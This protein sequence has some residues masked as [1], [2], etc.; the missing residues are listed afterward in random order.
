MFSAASVLFFCLCVR[1]RVRENQKEQKTDWVG[2]D[3][4]IARPPA[5]HCGAIRRV[6]RTAHVVTECVMQRLAAQQQQGGIPETHRPGGDT[7]ASRAARNRSLVTLRSLAWRSG[8]AARS[9]CK[10]QGHQEA[11]SHLA[12]LAD[13]RPL[14][15]GDELAVR[16]RRE[17]GAQVLLLQQLDRGGKR[18]HLE[19][20][21]GVCGGSRREVCVCVLCPHTRAR[22]FCA[23]MQS[24]KHSGTQPR[25]RLKAGGRRF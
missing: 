14:R 4:G 17:D 11:S 23:P 7:Q 12:G 25:S 21:G 6:G 24:K 9:G 19:F 2:V 22:P 8:T 3:G 10:D 1:W 15:D 13:G 20:A 18:R 16:W 5:V